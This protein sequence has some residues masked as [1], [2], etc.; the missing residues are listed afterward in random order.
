VSDS[1]KFQACLDPEVDS[2]PTPWVYT[3]GASVEQIDQE[4]FH[5]NGEC[6][7]RTLRSAADIF[8]LQ[9]VVTPFD[10][11][12]EAEALGCKVNWDNGYPTIEAGCITEVGDVLDLPLNISSE[13][14]FPEILDGLERL[15][16]NL[17]SRSAVAAVT[18]PGTLAKTL[19]SGELTEE[20]AIEMYLTVGDILTEVVRSYL[21][22]GADGILVVEPDSRVASQEG[23]SDAVGPILNLLEHYNSDALFVT[24]S[25]EPGLPSTVAKLGFDGVSGTPVGDID[26][27][28]SIPVGYGIPGEVLLSGG[29]SLDE[30]CARAE[31]FTFTTTALQVPIDATID[32][33]HDLMN[34]N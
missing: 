28:G 10:T 11:T 17:H 3:F 1:S 31:E 4:R 16:V 13:G 32:R 8:D 2:A 29:G 5:S 25:L 20:L 26:P 22:V 19:V 7:D 12:L 33:V 34:S 15:S 14:R 23:Y 6:I 30:H 9:V 27:A 24:E 18:G 21:E